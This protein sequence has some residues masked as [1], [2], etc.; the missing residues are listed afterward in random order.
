MGWARRGGCRKRQPNRGRVSLE[1]TH[2]AKKKVWLPE[3][4]R[5]VSEMHCHWVDLPRS[6]LI[7]KRQTD[8][9]NSC[10]LV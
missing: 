9:T 8:W 3:V 6:H 4:R 10:D 1:S 2:A 7:S 5:W